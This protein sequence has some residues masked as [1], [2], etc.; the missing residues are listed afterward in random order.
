MH[1]S[2]IIIYLITV[3]HKLIIT[4]LMFMTLEEFQKY[5]YRLVTYPLSNFSIA[6]TL[7]LTQYYC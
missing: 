7:A 5:V 1:V 3:V 2:K 4:F 6:F